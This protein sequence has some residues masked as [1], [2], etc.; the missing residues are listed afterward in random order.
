MNE[1]KECWYNEYL[2]EIVVS[3]QKEWPKIFEQENGKILIKNINKKIDTKKLKVIDIGCGACT[4]AQ[5][6]DFNSYTGYDLPHIIEGVS[7]N[8][9]QDNL[10]KQNYL[11]KNIEFKKGNF[12][13]DDLS[14]LSGYDAVISSAFLDVSHAPI[15]CLK[16]ILRYSSSYV[17]IHRQLVSSSPTECV[18]ESSY[19]G[20]KSSYLSNINVNDFEKTLKEFRFKKVFGIPLPDQSISI[21]NELSYKSSFLLQKI[22]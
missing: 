6:F 18:P 12:Y 7:K 20:Q 16:N 22:K 10:F 5:A 2:P 3:R 19:F 13:E 8:L 17:L 9:T 1:I 11:T 14:F 21:R 4:L 15:E